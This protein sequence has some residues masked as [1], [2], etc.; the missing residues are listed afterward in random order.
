MIELDFYIKMIIGL[1]TGFLHDKNKKYAAVDIGSN[2]VRLLICSV[3]SQN[4]NIVEVK[5]ISLV[6]VP[7]RLGFDGF[8]KNKIKT[9]NRKRL[10]DAMSAFKLLMKVHNVSKYKI[11]ATSHELRAADLRVVLLGMHARRHVLG[12][13]GGDANER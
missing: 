9:E 10:N 5:K 4:N 7:I 11:C 1:K 12:V 2:A 13:P 6:R 8:L 3:I